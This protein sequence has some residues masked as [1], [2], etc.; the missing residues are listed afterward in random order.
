MLATAHVNPR[1][2]GAYN[3]GTVDA[4]ELLRAGKAI[5]LGLLLGAILA[6]LARAR[7]GSAGN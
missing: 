1:A 5:A 6:L 7:S 4:D 2:H 3:R